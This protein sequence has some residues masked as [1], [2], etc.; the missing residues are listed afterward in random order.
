MSDDLG[1]DVAADV[2]RG[3]KR[4]PTKV[5]RLA[6]W[7]VAQR[8]IPVITIV[9]Q[10]AY[11][12]R[13][14]VVWVRSELDAAALDSSRSAISAHIADGERGHWLRPDPEP[15]FLITK[16]FE[17]AARDNVTRQ[18]GADGYR[19]IE[20]L[21]GDPALAELVIFF[22]WVIFFVHTDAQ[23]VAFVETS[24]A[25]QRK[26]LDYL[27][28]YDEFGVVK[29]ESFRFTLDSKET[30]DRDYAGSTYYYLK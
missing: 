28:S 24:A 23:K 10:M 14:V 15:P 18:L 29:A 17:S 27:S 11:E 26:V 1:W 22:G 5:A 3:T 20:A 16:S 7:I 19:A 13:R 4:N 6:E 8:G 2:V 25:W 30:L 9:D 21:I 12:R